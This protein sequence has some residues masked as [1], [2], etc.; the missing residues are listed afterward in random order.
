[1]AMVPA[2]PRRSGQDV[3]GGRDLRTMAKRIPEPVVHRLPNAAER[4]RKR[5]GEQKSG[6]D[7]ESNTR[8]RA[9][10]DR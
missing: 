7:S 1:M 6:T 2:R 8:K 10:G 4:D 3:R 5:P 9:G